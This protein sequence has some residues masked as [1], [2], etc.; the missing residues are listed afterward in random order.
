ME[1]SEIYSINIKDLSKGLVI[2]VL[3]GFILPLLAAIQTPGF[4]ILTANWGA[5]LTLGL[6]GAIAAFSGY[7]VKQ[8]FSN[9]KGQMFGKIG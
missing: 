8:F 1:T 4:D 7:M 9:K 3:G 6:N 2:A 5:I